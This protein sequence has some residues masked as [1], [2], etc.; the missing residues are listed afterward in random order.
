MLVTMGLHDYM[1]I[2]W[3]KENMNGHRMKYDGNDMVWWT[4]MVVHNWNEYAYIL[5]IN[6]E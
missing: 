3:Q 1:Y 6:K 2:F 5:I 4:V